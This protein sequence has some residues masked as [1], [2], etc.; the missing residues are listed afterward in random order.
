MSKHHDPE[1][2]Q[3]LAVGSSDLLACP[4]CGGKTVGILPRQGLGKPCKILCCSDGDCTA[5]VWGANEAEA[6]RRWNR[7]QAN[8]DLSVSAREKSQP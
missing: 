1:T 4:F 5:Y 7:R 6:T 2:G 8:A 3:P